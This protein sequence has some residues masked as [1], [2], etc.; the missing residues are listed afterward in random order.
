M[1]HVVAI[2]GGK[3]STALALRLR[4]VMP[5]VKFEFLCTPVG[6]EPPELF[7]HLDKLEAELGPIMRLRPLGEGDQLKA[8]IEREKMIPNFR[9]RFCTRIL[10]IVPTIEYLKAVAPCVQ[11]VGL[12]ADE[13]T[14]QGI[15]GTMDGVSQSYPFRE[16]G[17]G[18]SEVVEYLEHRGVSVPQR[19]DC[20]WCFHQKLVEWWNLWRKY[21]E[22]YAGAESF[23]SEF[24][25][26]FRSPE[27][28]TWPTGLKGLRERFEAGHKPRGAENTLQGTLWNCDK[29]ATCRVCTL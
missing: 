5:A 22:A 15:Y 29:D 3:D 1:R 27:R 14:R 21:P 16:W 11:Y 18:L 19:T 9:A 28:D 6:N 25:H 12:R 23:E 8:L 24:G 7:Q 26:T 17:W 10:K 13:E 20:A 2:S 4:D